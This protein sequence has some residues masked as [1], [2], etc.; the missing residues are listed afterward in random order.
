MDG[1]PATSSP[2]RPHQNVERLVQRNRLDNGLSGSTASAQ[3][4]HTVA[5]IGAGLMGGAIA[6]SNLRQGIPVV[7]NDCN[8]DALAAA[9]LRIAA[10][11]ALQTGHSEDECLAQVA[12]L[13]TTTDDP[14]RIGECDL[15]VESVV[16]TV[17]AKRALYA[18]LNP[19]LQTHTILASNT[20]TIP[21]ARLAGELIDPSRFCGIHFFHPVRH[22]SLVE[23]IRG[24]NTSD[25]TIATAVAYAKTIE[26]MPI[27]VDDGPGF[28][29]NRLL[30]PYLNEALEMLLDGASMEAVDG[31]ATDFGMAMGP[32]RILDEIGLDTTWLAGRVLWEAFPERV[33]ASPL[34]V[35]LLKKGRLGRKA[36]A[37]F[38][39]YAK[40]TSWDGP[41]QRDPAIDAILAQWARPPQSFTTE[42]ITHRLL[43]PMVL[44]ATR[45][46]EERRVR[47]PADI[48][49]GVLFGL[50]FPSCRGG[51]LCWADSLGPAK[52]LELLKPLAP[53]GPRAAPTRMLCEMAASGSRFYHV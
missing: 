46:L 7:L 34:M 2:D 36:G 21:I 14:G 10:E 27:V 4:V 48:D 28:L 6:A 16:E 9:P 44:E 17:A 22:R 37:G 45:L 51:L 20:S 52:I 32:L 18:R 19:H 35:T 41:G 5:V 3:T 23:V 43:L 26:K 12:R 31:A 40:T 15:I 49:L 24:P 13:L 8:P 53:L 29:V 25:P 50:G 1:I 33:V 39:A 42:S 47:E 11:L 30:V 38:F